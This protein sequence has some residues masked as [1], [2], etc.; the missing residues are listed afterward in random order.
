MKKL[1]L[2]PSL[3][4]LLQYGNA[5]TFTHGT[6]GINNER[7]TH[8]LVSTCSG[9]YLDNGGAGGN[10]SNSILGG[11][12]RV[13]CPNAAG[14]CMRATFNSF[15]TEGT[16]VSSCNFDYLTVGN[17]ATQNSTVMTLAGVT[18]GTGRI[19]GAPATPFS[20]TMPI[21]S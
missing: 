1:L 21:K 4:L 15:G 12:Y 13:F 6:V 10:Y 16:A 3:M 19:C 20:F 7:V 18:T 2:Y 14:Q 8:C 9:T 17:G 11:L 5:Q